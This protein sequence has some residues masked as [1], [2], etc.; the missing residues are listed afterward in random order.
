MIKRIQE[1]TQSKIIIIIKKISD[2][3]EKQLT[4]SCASVFV[5][6]TQHRKILFS[7]RTAVKVFIIS[8]IN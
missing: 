1:K 4:D 3:C 8:D 2:Q 6:P 7:F 5:I